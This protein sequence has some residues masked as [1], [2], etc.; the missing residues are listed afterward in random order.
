MP[1]IVKQSLINQVQGIFNDGSRGEMPVVRQTDGL[2]GPD[3]VTWRV[4]GDV[5]SMMVG[6]VAALL[7]QMLHPK[8]LAGVWDHS[9]FRH[10]MH[11]RLRR[12]ARFIALTTYG[13]RTEAEQAFAR[14]RAIHK[15]VG[16]KLHDGS[17][18]HAN[19][20]DLLLWVHATETLCFLD[21]WR[22]YSEP[23]MSIADQDRYFAET[24]IM[25]REL[26]AGSVPTS[27]SAM[28]ALIAQMR[29][30][31]QVDERTR[32]VRKLVL[33]Q[34]TSNLLSAPVQKL[35]G[36]AAVD[37]LPRWARRMHGLHSNPLVRPMV[38]SGTFGVAHT[39]RWAF[40][41]TAG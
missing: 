38:R 24:A 10:D 26:G 31:L 12:T 15:H 1:N 34:S 2:F 29:V 37:L 19:D 7:M 21:A 4:H 27:R 6:G 33:N 5:T 35:L 20:E 9:D 36:Q 13:S 22:R 25:A 18:Y 16:G 40:T 39:L 11:G 28:L 23:S 8:V 32:E 17:S 14:V 41:P 30:D 3:S